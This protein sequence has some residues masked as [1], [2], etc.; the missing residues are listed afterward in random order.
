VY[1]FDEDAEMPCR[2][3]WGACRADHMWRRRSHQG[4]IDARIAVIDVGCWTCPAS[5]LS[6]SKKS[7]RSALG[8]A[9][10]RRLATRPLIAGEPGD[11]ENLNAFRRS[12]AAMLPRLHILTARPGGLRH[13]DGGLRTSPSHGSTDS[14]RSPRRCS[15]LQGGLSS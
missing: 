4:D 8:R 6:H 12:S 10:R 15:D 2:I 9:V 14:C 11:R 1:S 13:A 5:M 3:V 7:Q